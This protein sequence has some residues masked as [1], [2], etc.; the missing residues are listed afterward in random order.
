VSADLEHCD[1]MGDWFALRCDDFAGCSIEGPAAEWQDVHDLLA[2]GQ[3]GVV[4]F[5]RLCCV[6]QKQH[7][8]SLWSPRNAHRDRDTFRM[9]VKAGQ[10][11]AGVIASALLAWQ[12]SK[13]AT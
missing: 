12:R 1:W 4:Q 5:K 8:V 11:F 2:A 10:E 13:V 3:P 6:I 7:G 9:S